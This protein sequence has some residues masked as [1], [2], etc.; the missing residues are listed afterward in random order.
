[1]TSEMIQARIRGFFARAFPGRSLRDGD[2][3]FALGFGNSL[4]AMQLVDFVEGEFGLT[5]NNEDLDVA[6]F[7]TIASIRSLVE[8]KVSAASAS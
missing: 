2:D 6:N 7:S 4:F 5:I 3:I 8:R 1:M